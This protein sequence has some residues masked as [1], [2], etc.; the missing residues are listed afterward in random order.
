MSHEIWELTSAKSPIGF[1]VQRKFPRSVDTFLESRV[2]S[3]G[4]ERA[5]SEK[6]SRSAVCRVTGL[7]EKSGLVES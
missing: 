4:K 5:D 1:S 3:I 2:V 7:F 6:K